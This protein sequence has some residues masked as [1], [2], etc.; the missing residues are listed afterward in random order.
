MA[1]LDPDPYPLP[2]IDYSKGYPESNAAHDAA[3][4]AIPADRII[5]FPR[6][7]GYALYLVK[8]VSPPVVQH[9]PYGDAWTVEP[10]LIR[11]LRAADLRQ[12]LAFGK[13]QRALFGSED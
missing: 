7:D 10:A 3:F 2:A 8:S 12:M 11:G 13:A 6:G 5:Q 1:K 4:D 9:I